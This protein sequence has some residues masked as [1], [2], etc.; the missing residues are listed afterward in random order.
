[1]IVLYGKETVD[2]KAALENTKAKLAN[3]KKELQ[4]KKDDIAKLNFLDSETKQVH[5]L[6][7]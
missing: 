7:I 3:I 6:R 1:M 5:T 4:E 2:L